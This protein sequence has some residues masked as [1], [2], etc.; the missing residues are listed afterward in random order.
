MFVST[1]C[2]F[3]PW[4]KRNTIAPHHSPLWWNSPPSGQVIRKHRHV[5]GLCSSSLPGFNHLRTTIKDHVNG[6]ESLVITS[7]RLAH[8]S[9]WDTM[10]L[11]RSCNFTPLWL[12]KCV[13]KASAKVV[14]LL[15]LVYS[16]I[17]NYSY[18]DWETMT[19]KR[20]CNL[21]P[22]WLAKCAIKAS[23]TVVALLHLVY[24]G[25]ENVTMFR[26]QTR[27]PD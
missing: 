6:Q 9:D 10:T 12:A 2:S 25:I 17:E 8:Y 24:S 16:G 26:G 20:S 5:R 4:C 15:H 19:L 14:A 11:K 23:A 3:E 21:T 22:L 1:A 18:S 7:S 13:I 27:L